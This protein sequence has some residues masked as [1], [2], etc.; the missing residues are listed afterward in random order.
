MRSRALAT[1][2]DAHDTICVAW[3]GALLGLAVRIEEWRRGLRRQALRLHGSCR[4]LLCSAGGRDVER[5]IR[6]RRGSNRTP[7][8]IEERIVRLHVDAPHLGTGQLRRLVE[9]VI[10]FSAARE[11][12]R[13]ILLRNRELI[14]DLEN[15]RRRPATA[16]DVSK[17]NEL[18]GAD[19]TLVW[20]LGCLPVWV[21]GVVDYC[22]S[23][24]VSLVPLRTPRAAHINAALE[25]AIARHGPPDRILT[26]RG[27]VFRSAAFHE[28]LG[29]RSIAHTMTRRCHPWTNGRIERLFRTFN[30]RRPSA[31]SSGC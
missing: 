4:R 13:K 21:L 20:V 31:R 28:F 25:G 3:I 2:L 5:P 9:R 11:T 1:V 10:G 12:I 7:P 23:R 14:S 29:S 18:W 22:G 26:D 27:S 17:P 16:I 19:L 15:D 30:S 6:R 8:D 24:L